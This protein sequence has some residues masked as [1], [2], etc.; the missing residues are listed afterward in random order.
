MN[1][2]RVYRKSGIRN[3][4]QFTNPPFTALTDLD[5]VKNS[6]VHILPSN[7]GKDGPLSIEP[8]TY[9]LLQNKVSIFVD[10]IIEISDPLGDPRYVPL[11]IRKRITDFH[12][13]NRNFRMLKRVISVISNYNS[14]I[15]V[16]YSFLDSVYSYKKARMN[17]YY[18]H[19]NLV[20]EVNASIGKYSQL[21]KRSQFIELELPFTVRSIPEYKNLLSKN[22][23]VIIG[24]LG[25]SEYWTITIL[26]FI[27]DLAKDRFN[28]FRGNESL[29]YY[30][31]LGDGLVFLSHNKLVE[32]KEDD[33]NIL[34]RV[35]ISFIDELVKKQVTE[36]EVESNLDVEII[37]VSE[38]IE[39]EI[40]RSTEKMVNDGFITE[41]ERNRLLRLSKSY[42][43][44]PNPMGDGTLEKLIEPPTED[45]K[46]LDSNKLLESET[47]LDKSMEQSSLENFD[48]KYVKEL[49][50]KDIA[51]CVMNFQ[52][53]GLAVTD[54]TVMENK[55]AITNSYTYKIQFTPIDGKPSTVEFKLPKVREDGTYTANNVTVRMDKQRSDMPIRKIKPDRVSLTSYF[56]KL[57]VDRDSKAVNDYGRWATRK[58]LDL[59][60]GEDSHVKSLIA[61]N[62]FDSNFKSPRVYSAIK[63]LTW[64]SSPSQTPVSYTHLTLPTILLV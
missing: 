16:N 41:M 60:E 44:L 3:R 1:I 36:D 11:N 19:A 37:D 2:E 15:L 51:R 62:V 46:S 27:L 48:S 5:V 33:P 10:H 63:D 12:K 26:S 32:L 14:T 18:K 13:K 42:M 40:N 21:S 17:N 56:G 34:A 59:Y 55:D 61:G 49:L 35:F 29:Y 8:L 58:I 25:E 57:F 50:Q 45:Q 24:E 28:L 23:N 47:I 54:Y 64:E 53:A 43:E 31:S 9:S 52:R 4:G 39:S 38:P 6:I 7:S 22:M 30:W 20:N